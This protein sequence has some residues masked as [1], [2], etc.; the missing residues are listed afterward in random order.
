M[1]LHGPWEYQPLSRWIKVA[2]GT[3]VETTS[4][5]PPLGRV[6]VPADWGATLGQDYRGRV[7]YRRSFGRPTGLEPRERVWLVIEGVDAS[8]DVALNSQPIGR[9]DGYALRAAFDITE[10]LQARNQLEIVAETP[11][12]LD[13]RASQQPACLRPGREHDPGGLIREIRLEVRHEVYVKRL[14]VGAMDRGGSPRLHLSAVV[15]GP[16]MD[17]LNLHITGMRRE[18][19]FVP[20]RSG[21]AVDLEVAMPGLPRWTPHSPCELEPIEIRLLLRGEAIWEAIYLLAFRDVELA[22]DGR[23]PLVNGQPL[24]ELQRLDQLPTEEELHQFDARGAPVVLV[25]PRAWAEE[26]CR[27]LAHHPSIVAW[28][29]PGDLQLRPFVLSNDCRKAVRPGKRQPD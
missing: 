2:D 5:L 9:V 14:S 29:T 3:W 7:C 25:I 4:D 15:G 17:G 27:E 16:D 18:L 11:P 13:L 19:A 6:R 8:G 26:I 1:R 20:V 23:S 10:Q 21:Q 24:P 12:E 28:A 22:H